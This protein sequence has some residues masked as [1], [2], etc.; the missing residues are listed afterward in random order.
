VDQTTI[1]AKDFKGSFT[2]ADIHIS[3]DEKLYASNG[4]RNIS[5][6]LEFKKRK[7]ESKGLNKFLGKTRNFAIDPTQFF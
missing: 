7:L 2:G 6:N 3:P 1:L 5:I 4:G